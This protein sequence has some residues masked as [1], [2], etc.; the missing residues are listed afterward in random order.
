LPSL[1]D[2]ACLICTSIAFKPIRLA[3]GHLFCVRCLVK[4]QR[5]GKA[6]CPLCRS[7]VVLLADKSGYITEIEV[8]VHV[9]DRLGSLDSQLMK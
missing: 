3:C 2:Y 7:K 4:M 8:S 5:A 9:A 6:E 1:D